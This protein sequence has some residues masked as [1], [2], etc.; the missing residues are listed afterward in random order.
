[1]PTNLTSVP[2][3]AGTNASG[4][5]LRDIKPPLPI[6]D[7]WLWIVII[8]T[9]LALILSTWALWRWWKRRAQRPQTP[10]AP[11]HARARARLNQ[12]LLLIDTPEPFVI[13]VS[14]AIRTYLE[15]Q[16]DWRAPERTTEEFLA[17]IQTSE[18]LTTVQRQALASFLEQSDLVKF[19]RLE[20]SRADLESMHQT[21]LHLIDWTEPRPA[22][23][24]PTP[25]P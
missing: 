11:P 15:E 9:V 6:A 3:A 24:P 22:P 5:I 13:E 7:P 20:P 16:F 14:L 4:E 1:M 25:A 2:T 10:V 19:A 18:V 23:A 8:G 21:A 12:A 17:E